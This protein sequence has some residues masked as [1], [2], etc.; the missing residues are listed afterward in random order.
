MGKKRKR[1]RKES[2]ATRQESTKPKSPATPDFPD[3][4][5]LGDIPSDGNVVVQVPASND[6]EQVKL[7]L[8]ENLD[9]SPIPLRLD[10]KDQHAV[11]L[12]L[13]P[14]T[15][16]YRLVKNGQVWFPPTLSAHLAR[17]HNEWWLRHDVHQLDR[18]WTLPPQLDDFECL[19][20]NDPW[21]TVVQ[22][23]HQ[24][25]VLHLRPNPE[26]MAE[27]INRAVIQA[28]TAKQQQPILIVQAKRTVRYSK[29]RFAYPELDLGSIEQGGYVDKTITLIL[30]GEGQCAGTL[31]ATAAEHLST[32]HLTCD[33]GQSES[34]VHIPLRF[35]TRHLGNSDLPVEVLFRTNSPSLTARELRLPVRYQLIKLTPDCP[36]IIGDLCKHR[37]L[38]SI[39]RFQRSDAKP[40]QVAVK[41]GEW[42]KY[43]SATLLVCDQIRFELR[44][45]IN[46]PDPPIAWATIVDQMSSLRYTL[47]FSFIKENTSDATC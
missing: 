30:S 43:L 3:I 38:P 10:V 46:V 24:P 37:L 20:C 26:L 14:G 1:Q 13:A 40:I 29:P 22:D 35:N 6:S 5:D 41:P 8:R 32:V 39:V 21:L 4:F 25:T 16:H 18:T 33:P 44:S 47:L 23:N 28:V 42:E 15:Y 19:Y 45:G 17:V 2:L 12:T 31:F 9:Q 34:A 7:I 36:F 27:G 11:A